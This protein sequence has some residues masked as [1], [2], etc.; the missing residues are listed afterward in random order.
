MT[1]QILEARSFNPLLI[2]DLATDGGTGPEI[3]QR[4]E[5]GECAQ[6]AAVA[7]CFGV[8]SEDVARAEVGDDAGRAVVETAE[9]SVGPI[10]R[11]GQS[12]RAVLGEKVN[13]G[14]STDRAHGRNAKN[15]LH[16]SYIAH[17]RAN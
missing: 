14:T 10:A 11:H 13:A 15:P 16:K 9:D 4:D 8:L 3:E 1:D 2:T 5:L 17:L 7:N 12:F 6:E